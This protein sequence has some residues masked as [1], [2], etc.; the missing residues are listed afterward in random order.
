MMIKRQRMTISDKDIT[1]MIAEPLTRSAGFE[2][3]VRQYS[4]PLYWKIR[5]IVIS[6][7]DA[8]DVLQNTFLKIWKSIGTFQGKSTLSTW[9]YRIAINE[10]LDFLRHQRQSAMSSVDDN[11]KMAN[12]LMADDY[13]DGDRMQ[14]WLQEAVA[15]LPEVQRT[16]FVLKYFYEMTYSEIGEVLGTSEGALKA[17]YHLAVKKITEYLKRFD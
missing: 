7:E 3:L 17:S 9:L 11:K 14:A 13:F 8:D 12:Q 4:E 15:R 16:V 2:A 6:H 10:A 1:D 5:R